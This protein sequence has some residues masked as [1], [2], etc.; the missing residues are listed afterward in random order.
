MELIDRA[1]LPPLDYQFEAFYKKQ[2]SVESILKDLQK[3]EFK[4]L[5]RRTY[6]KEGIEEFQ[7]LY[8]EVGA[9]KTTL[10]YKKSFG[11]Y[12]HINTYILPSRINGKFRYELPEYLNLLVGSSVDKLRRC[13]YCGKIFLAPRKD[14]QFCR[15]INNRPSKCRHSFNQRKFRSQEKKDQYQYNRA[16][17]ENERT[18]K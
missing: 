2:L 14:S 10:D 3:G 13:K 1:N 18:E 17:A 8:K 7:K 6:K 4:T 11:H 15:P 12:N 16:M 9:I 5:L